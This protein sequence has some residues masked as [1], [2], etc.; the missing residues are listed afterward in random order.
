MSDS[1]IPAGLRRLVIER[2]GNRCEYCLMPER[3]TFARHEIDHVVA[4]K[5]GGRTAADNLALSCTLCNKLKGSDISTID[6][7]TGLMAPL[8]HPRLNQWSDHFR[9]DGARIEPQT[10]TGRATT[11]LLQFNRADRIAERELLILAGVLRP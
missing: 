11:R 10:A 3:F 4:V 2:A 8:F 6:P 7:A 9:L 5:H 1:Y